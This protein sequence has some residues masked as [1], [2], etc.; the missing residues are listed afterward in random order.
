MSCSIDGGG[1][2]GMSRAAACLHPT[3]IL[4]AGTDG[5]LSGL[6]T[7]EAYSALSTKHASVSIHASRAR[8]G[9]ARSLWNRSVLLAQR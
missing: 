1:F 2:M 5:L 4:M 7:E 3:A 6:P 8:S 9:V